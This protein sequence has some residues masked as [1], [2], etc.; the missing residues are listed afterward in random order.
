[1][2]LFGSKALRQAP[3]IPRPSFQEEAEHAAT[4]PQITTAGVACPTINDIPMPTL[5]KILGLLSATDLARCA[6]VCRAWRASATWSPL[7]SC[8]CQARWV[9]WSVGDWHSKPFKHTEWPAAWRKR[10]QKEKQC[11]ELLDDL[12]WPQRHHA[13][14]RAIADLGP[15]IL[16]CLEMEAQRPGSLQEGRR[17]WA[18]KA[19][20]RA[21][22]IW[23][24]QQMHEAPEALRLPEYQSQIELGALLVAQIHAP[25]ADLTP[26]PRFLDQLAEELRRRL[27]EADIT[28]GLPAVEMLSEMLF[29]KAGPGAASNGASMTLTDLSG[30]ALE[31]SLKLP[32]PGFGMGLQ[33][34]S[35]GYYSP[36]NSLLQHV[37]TAGKGI[38]ISLAIIHAAVGRRAGLPISCVNMPRHFMNRFGDYNHPDERFIDAF[39]GGK[40]LTR[41]AAM[42]MLMTF[43]GRASAE[44]L[45]PAT[46]D[47]VWYRCCY[48]LIS[49]YHNTR[50][51]PTLRSV[52][53][54]ALAL[55]P[56]DVSGTYN[57]IS[58]DLCMLRAQ[59]AT[60]LDD[61]S[62]AL[63]TIQELD[64]S[65]MPVDGNLE[66]LASNLQHIKASAE[67]DWNRRRYRT[68]EAA[69]VQWRVGQVMKHRKFG[70]G[71]VIIGWNYRCMQSEEWIIAMGVDRLPD[72]GCEQPFYQVLVDGRDRADATTYVAQCNIE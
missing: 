17:C 38:P 69:R 45:A 72:G 27:E 41:S 56:L 7:W 10:L 59:I 23:C 25:F 20:A 47:R 70:Y 49:L 12:V 6:T 67:A 68:E 15:D 24:S 55:S 8:L 60:G 32:A 58:A 54:L 48:N 31:A 51:L 5:E 22:A 21:Q 57:K 39:D 11:L 13:T 37:L 18:V 50:S 28:G 34:D 2:V 64:E 30:S 14:V 43:T 63:D 26:V 65:G 40:M 46:P 61:F 3:P 36:E 71:G 62:G 4:H 35:E 19:A 29:G 52:L 44:D 42:A 66:E 1:M 33:G 9:V 16:E 53:D